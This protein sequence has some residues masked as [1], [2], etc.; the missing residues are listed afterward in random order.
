MLGSNP[1][2][3]TGGHANAHKGPLSLLPE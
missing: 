3:T 1:S 2:A